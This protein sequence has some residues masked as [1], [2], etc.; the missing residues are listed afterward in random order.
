MKSQKNPNFIL[1]ILKYVNLIIF[2]NT[3]MSTTQFT[4]ESRGQYSAK[5]Y[6]ATSAT[7]PLAAT[8]ISRRDPGD[9]DVQIE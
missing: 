6:S 2:T 4:S 1:L 5:A 3:I 8:M 7:S 9:H